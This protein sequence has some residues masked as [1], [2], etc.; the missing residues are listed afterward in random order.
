[1]S[2]AQAVFSFA[3]RS[4]LANSF[5]CPDSEIHVTNYGWHSVRGVTVAINRSLFPGENRCECR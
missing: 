3:T 4:M 5:W 2:F 1:M